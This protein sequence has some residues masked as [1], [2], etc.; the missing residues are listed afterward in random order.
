MGYY[1]HYELEVASE[2]SEELE[3]FFNEDTETCDYGEGF[4][5][6]LQ[7]GNMEACK[8]YEHNETM[9]E[10]SKKFPETLF[11]LKGEGESA[12]DM[13]KKYYNISLDESTSYSKFACFAG[14]K[15]RRIFI[16]I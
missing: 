16:K 5:D 7:N 12:G 13:W 14:Q 15:Y 2:V 11:V 4:W 9:I 3:K 10:V 8:W 1:T 6:D